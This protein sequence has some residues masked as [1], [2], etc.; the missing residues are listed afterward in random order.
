[1][2]FIIKIFEVLLNEYRIKDMSHKDESILFTLLHLKQI[3]VNFKFEY[4]IFQKELPM[5][6]TINAKFEVNKLKTEIS[7]KCIINMMKIIVH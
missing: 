1:M 7:T 4:G 5:A 6:N 2:H 3:F